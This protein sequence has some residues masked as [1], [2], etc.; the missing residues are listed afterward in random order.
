MVPTDG[1]RGAI[2]VLR[3]DKSARFAKD[4]PILSGCLAIPSEL[5]VV[6]Q[7]LIRANSLVVSMGSTAVKEELRRC[8]SASLCRDRSAQ[9]VCH[10]AIY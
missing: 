4:S 1:Y 10:I 3:S 5:L 8:P 6:H 2:Q 7:N 9:G